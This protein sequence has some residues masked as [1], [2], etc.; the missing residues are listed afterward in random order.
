M[1]GATTGVHAGLTADDI[2]G[3][4]A[5]YGTRPPDAYDAAAANDSRTTGP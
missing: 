3:I 2:A 4:R 1:Y 5:I